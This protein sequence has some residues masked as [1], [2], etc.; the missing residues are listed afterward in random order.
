MWVVH[1]WLHGLLWLY[2][3]ESFVNSIHMQYHYINH[4]YIDFYVCHVL[5]MN[6]SFLLILTWTISLPPDSIISASS[7][8]DQRVLIVNNIGISS[9]QCC[10]YG[11]CYCSNLSLALEHIQSNTEIRITQYI[12]TWCSTI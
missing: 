11:K 10:A 3:K 5:R 9:V 4:L 12:I 1:R 6:I 8:Y 7:S 2:F